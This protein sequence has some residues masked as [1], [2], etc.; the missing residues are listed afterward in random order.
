MDAAAEAKDTVEL[1]R[2][3]D[4]AN[5]AGRRVRRTRDPGVGVV[6]PHRMR[7]AGVHHRDSPIVTV[8]HG[9]HPGRRRA[10][11]P[12]LE[13][14]TGVSAERRV[15]AAELGRLEDLEQACLA[16]V[17]DRVVGQPALGFGRGG[18]RP[19]HGDELAGSADEGLC[20]AFGLEVERGAHG[21]NDASG[22]GGA[23]K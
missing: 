15:A 2:V 5:E 6:I 22:C 10:A 18:A 3:T 1:E 9:E 11:A 14:H 19:K 16:E 7:S 17:A 4:L 20:G 21:D 8:E 12:E 13:R 23:R